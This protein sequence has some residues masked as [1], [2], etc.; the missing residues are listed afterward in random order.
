MKK[1]RQDRIAETLTYIYGSEV[2]RIYT[3]RTANM[4]GR[5]EKTIST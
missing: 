3:D 2:K 5:K 4:Y 1:G